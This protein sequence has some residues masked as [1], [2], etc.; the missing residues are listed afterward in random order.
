MERMNV[1]AQNITARQ[2]KLLQHRA[3]VRGDNATVR[4]CLEALEYERRHWTLD[5][6]ALAAREI[7]ATAISGEGLPTIAVGADL[8]YGR[9]REFVVEGGAP[10]VECRTANGSIELR[11]PRCRMTIWNR[12][13]Q[14][15]PGETGSSNGRIFTSVL[16]DRLG[17]YGGTVW[18]DAWPALFAPVR[19]TAQ[20]GG[21]FTLTPLG[22]VLFVQA[23]TEAR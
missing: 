21:G 6:R 9:C 12:D 10:V 23:L 7:C 15:T 5:Q 2:L 20:G 14:A 18:P 13:R 16:G 22:R 19:R 17:S 4:A 1:N 8:Y 11:Q 3:A